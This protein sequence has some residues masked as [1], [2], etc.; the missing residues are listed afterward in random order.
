MAQSLSP[1]LKAVKD[2]SSAALL[3]E[4]AEQDVINALIEACHLG[5]RTSICH[6]I[7]CVCV[8]VCVCVFLL[9]LQV[10]LLSFSVESESTF[11]DYIKGG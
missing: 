11:L 4:G 2:A 6:Q 1:C 7:E 8:C 3:C 9:L 10:T 5:V